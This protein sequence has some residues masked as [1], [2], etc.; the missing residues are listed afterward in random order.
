MD[1]VGKAIILVGA[2]LVVVGIAVTFWDRIPWLGKLPG[3]I[4]YR[5]GNFHAYFPI[6][7]SVLLSVLLSLVFWIIARF[8]RH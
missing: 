2:V 4:H 5:R 1:H 8:V 6:V 7:T 3:D